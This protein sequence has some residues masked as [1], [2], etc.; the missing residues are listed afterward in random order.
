M[1]RKIDRNNL[2]YVTILS[3]LGILS[4]LALSLNQAGLL[5]PAVVYG[6]EP[7]DEGYFYE[8]TD[9]DPSN[10][11]EV[12]GEVKFLDKKYE[13]ICIGGKLHQVFC[14]SSLRVRLSG[15]YEC[16]NGCSEGVC[17]S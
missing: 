3:V 17:T 14:D 9:S 12:K 15:A 4:I 13:D 1:A 2:L 7:L 16:P 5:D 8:C 10:L 11:F 6:R